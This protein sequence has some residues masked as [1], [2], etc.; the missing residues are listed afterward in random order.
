MIQSSLLIRR[1]LIS[2]FD[3]SNILEFAQS[4]IQRGI[5]LLSTGGTAQILSDAGLPVIKISDYT[6]LP[7][8]MD[9]RVKTL[10]YKVYAGIL[11]RRGLDDAIMRQYNIPSIDMVVVNFYSFNSLLAKNKKYSQEE[12]LDRIDISGPS[13]VRAAAKNYKNVAIVVNN[14]SYKKILDEI[15]R[16]DGL[17]SLDTRFHLAV[18]AFKYVTEYD[19]T[20]SDYFNHQLRSNHHTSM[21]ND[22][23]YD[24]SYSYFPKNLTFMNLKFIKKQD[25]RYGENPHQRAAFYMDI[26]KKHT[27]SISDAQ[28]LQGKPLSYNNIVDMDTAL[29]C[30]KMFDEPTCV[31][32]KHTNPCGVATS[33]TIC[34]AYAKAYQADPISAFGGIIAFNRSLDKKTAQSIISQQF[35]EAI[36]APNI[37]RD[38]IS[39]VS[40]KKHVR[41]LRCGMWTPRTSDIDFKRINGGLLIQD[42]DVMT[43]LEHLEIVTI[44]QP[45]KEEMKDALFCW[46]VVKFVKSNAIVCGKNCQTIGIGTGQMNRVYAA[47]IATS[48]RERKGAL[49]T[50]GSVMASDAF[51]PFSDVVHIASEIGIKCIIQ[52]GGSIR[53]QEIIKTADRYGIAMI[54]THIRHFRH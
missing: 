5:Q 41:I 25:M 28:Q 50:K 45:T 16:C 9:G 36:V 20:I 10:H 7:E 18:K 39:I 44:R 24:Q 14:D 47:K 13:M 23:H 40:N 12:M 33:D 49:N 54:F 32:V 21:T 15:N 30:A 43:N 6:K 42:C 38:C 34:T 31:I 2:V 11:G 1:V 37:N 4:L 17:L 3:K 19:N 35:V 51:F 53:D 22:H 48:F 52:P 29:E 26:S 8:I 46:K 27:G